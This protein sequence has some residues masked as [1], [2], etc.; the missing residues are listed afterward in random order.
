[1]E[2]KWK[3]HL[4]E[5][6]YSLLGRQLPADSAAATAGEYIVD[7]SLGALYRDRAREMMSS[8]RLRIR[9]STH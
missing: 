6:N 2:V 4:Q 5:I 3:H 7:K 1:M 8:I 9:P